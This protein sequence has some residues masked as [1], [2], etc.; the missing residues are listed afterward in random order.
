M[1][2]RIRASFQGFFGASRSRVT[3]FYGEF[4]RSICKGLAEEFYICSRFPT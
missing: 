4:E 2:K 1:I 3:A